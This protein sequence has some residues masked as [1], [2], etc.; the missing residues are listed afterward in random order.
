MRVFFILSTLLS[1]FALAND[2]SF[3]GDGATVYTTKELRVRMAKENIILTYDNKSKS[4]TRWTANCTFEFE[5][6]SDEKVSLTMGFPNWKGF[7]DEVEPDAYVI[8]DFT[9]LVDGNPVAS[10][11][12]D[13]SKKNQIG[14]WIKGKNLATFD[15]AYVWPV[16][17][18]PKGK[19]TVKNKFQ[20][21]GFSSNGPFD[22]FDH[23]PPTY[24]KIKKSHTFWSVRKPG[25]K[26]IDYANALVG[27]V[28]YITTTGQTWSGP[29]GEATITMDIPERLQEKPHLMV[30]LPQGYHM[31]KDKIVWHFTNYKPK[32]EITLYFINNVFVP[33]EI[34]E[35]QEEQEAMSKGFQYADQAKAWVRFASK[36]RVDAD[37]VALLIANTKNP[38]AKK[39]LEKAKDKLAS[40][41]WSF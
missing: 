1:S 9:T 29:I 28:A 18:A 31:S 17:I 22:A 27:A 4:R 21:G 10:E 19:V 40:P 20:F 26:D 15:G 35:T 36:S 32:E 5:N 16:E 41:S 34:A 12:K 33:E 13:I 39:V 30:P 24:P 11:L 25:K 23:L 2:A 37:V 6:M 14:P 3:H 7:G 8:K 38:D